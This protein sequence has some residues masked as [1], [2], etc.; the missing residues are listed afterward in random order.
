M[1]F[2]NGSVLIITPRIYPFVTKPHYF[3]NIP[4][5]TPNESSTTY[6]E[7]NTTEQTLNDLASL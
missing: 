2:R 5:D 3:I 1:T 6:Q 7:P 4:K